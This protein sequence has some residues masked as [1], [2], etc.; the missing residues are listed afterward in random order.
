SEEGMTFNN[1]FVSSPSCA[2]SRAS[3]LTGLMPARNG[4][5]TNHSFPQ[6]G[7]PYLVENFKDAG[8][9]VLAF[10]KVAHYKGNVK[11]GFHFHHDKQVN[12]YQ[13][14]QAYFDSAAVDGPICIFIGDRRPHVPWIDTIIYETEKVDLP[15]YFID[16]PATR[17]H[18]AQYYTDVTGLDK[19]MGQVLQLVENELGE[20]VLTVFTSDHG[21]QWPFGKWNLYDAGI[22]TPLIVRWPGKIES[23]TQTEAMVSWVDI[24]PTLLDIVGAPL[25]QDLDGKSF[26]SVLLGK[27][28]SFREEIFTTHTGDGKFNIYPMRSIRTE[29]YKLIHNLES[30][31]YHTNHSDLLRKPG[32]GKYWDS[33]DSAA[34]E[35]PKAQSIVEA[36]YIRPEWEFFDLSVDEHEQRNEIHNSAYQ[37]IIV[38][39][40][41]QLEQWLHSQGDTQKPHRKPYPTAGPKPNKTFVKD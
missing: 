20:N 25:P 29:R 40:R 1:A 21:A 22:R 4:A 38:R 34:K 15:P 9:R 35:D 11:C 12:L 16:T 8:Y 18:R 13:N 14:V 28:T 27:Q 5:E 33:W 23:G 7:I 10:G 30:G 6:K 37:E 39:M 24:L 32:A 41:T 2:P 31:A 3:L 36:Y 26:Q 19:E 17:E